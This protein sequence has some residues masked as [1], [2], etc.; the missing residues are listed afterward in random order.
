MWGLRL[1]TA[2]AFS[3]MLYMLFFFSTIKSVWILFNWNVINKS[4][5]WKT[6]RLM[7]QASETGNAQ[8][9]RNLQLPGMCYDHTVFYIAFA[10][11]LLQ[12]CIVWFVIFFLFSI[13]NIINIKCLTQ[14]IMGYKKAWRE[15]HIITVQ[16]LTHIIEEYTCRCFCYIVMTPINL[17]IIAYISFMSVWRITAM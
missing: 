11:I 2:V 7:A 16:A 6:C 15:D 14:T 12:W 10:F 5:C 3:T 8:W 13:C 1:C 17:N 9:V 4:W